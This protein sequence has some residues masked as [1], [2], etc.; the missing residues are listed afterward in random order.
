MIIFFVVSFNKTISQTCGTEQDSIN[1]IKVEAKL[2]WSTSEE[3]PKSICI[4]NHYQCHIKDTVYFINTAR[5]CKSDSAL[6]D[7][8][9]SNLE[10]LK[11]NVN[12]DKETDPLIGICVYRSCKWNFKDTFDFSILDEKQIRVEA[13]D[14]IQASSSL[15]PPTVSRFWDFEDSNGDLLKP[16][17][18]MVFPNPAISNIHITAN[19]VNKP[20]QIFTSS[21]TL[22][23]E[24]IIEEFI[25]DSGDTHAMNIDISD[26]ATGV[27]LI[28][29]G[30][31]TGRFV[32]E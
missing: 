16:N 18:I 5:Y 30:N 12:K 13:T 10:L 25:F 8:N 6:S 15:K 28:V 24:I 7:E 32:K 22:V 31:Q 14:S 20:I 29:T 11:D 21:G 4:F 17:P 26:L 3:P 2:K 19:G 23:K 1:R 27:Y 9:S